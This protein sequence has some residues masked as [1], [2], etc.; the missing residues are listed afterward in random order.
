MNRY[1]F[2]NNLELF[3]KTKEIIQQE[4]QEKIQEDLSELKH[5]GTLGQKWGVRKWQNYDGTFNEA[6]KER[7]FGKS[8]QTT[9][10]EE[11]KIGSARSDVKEYL[12][13]RNKMLKK[14]THG[15][16]N[17]WYRDNNKAA[18][19]QLLKDA[20]RVDKQREKMYKNQLKDF[21]DDP[22]ELVSDLDRIYKIGSNKQKVGST[23]PTGNGGWY[24]TDYQ[25]PDGTLTK[26]GEKLLK[27]YTKHPKFWNITNV[28]DVDMYNKATGN[29]ARNFDKEKKAAE[30]EQ[31]MTNLKNLDDS[32]KVVHE[33]KGKDITDEEFDKITKDSFVDVEDLSQEDYDEIADLGLYRMKQ[34]NTLGNDAE[35]GDYWG[36]RMWFMEEDQTDGYPQVVDFYRKGYSK[37]YVEKYLN[38]I[39]DMDLLGDEAEEMGISPYLNSAAHHPGS[40]INDIYDDG[41]Q[42]Q[43]IGSSPDSKKIFENKTDADYM[44]K[45]GNFDDKKYWKDKEKAEKYLSE[46]YDKDFAET[47]KEAYDTTGE[48]GDVDAEYIKYKENPLD[49]LRK[50]SPDPKYRKLTDKDIKKATK[51]AEKLEKELE[52]AD[53]SKRRDIINNLLKDEKYK[54]LFDEIAANDKK[55]SAEALNRTEE[56]FNDFD[57]KEIRNLAIAGITNMKE[58]GYYPNPTMEDLANNAWFYVYEDGNQGDNTAEYLYATMEKGVK[59][60]ELEN[61]YEKLHVKKDSLDEGITTL[62]K[63]PVLTNVNEKYLKEIVDRKL[64]QNDSDNNSYWHLYAASEGSSST[65]SDATKKNYKEAKDI[66]KKLDSSCGNGDGWDFLNQAIQNLDMSSKEL[67]SMTQADWDRINAEINKLKK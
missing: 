63:N 34:N 44:D 46:N 55:R 54:D 50:Y 51:E 26:K 60:D 41:P 38:K 15:D 33:L 19:K 24:N 45:D 4:E 67:S 36:G 61:L 6:G 42:D 58:Y 12:K 53:W 11:D 23:H 18:D 9:S 49:Y 14:R 29:N 16:L 66:V 32:I 13:F 64:E 56:I 43:K 65:P 52:N 40:M 1:D 31:L 48:W 3:H 5:Y 62:K 2:Y 39:K 59:G 20:K 7:Y 21:Y 27:R 28:I 57:D 47:I 8:S 35:P 25:N 37:D 17:K 10:T 30:K 22:N